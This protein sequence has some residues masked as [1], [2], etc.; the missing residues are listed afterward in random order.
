LEPLPHRETLTIYNGGH[1][2]QHNYIERNG[3]WRSTGQFTDY[4]VFFRDSPQVPWRLYG[5]YYSAWTAQAAAGV[6]SA[7]GNLVSV[8]PH[9]A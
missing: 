6:L 8:R 2:E 1:V 7:N 5:T 9:C 4:D 3:S